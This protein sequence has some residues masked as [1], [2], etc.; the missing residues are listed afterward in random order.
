MGS[1]NDTATDSRPSE[2]HESAASA[3]EPDFVR[4]S[5]VRAQA[6]DEMAAAIARELNGPLTALLLYMG[7]IKHH[8][9]QL[10]PA[11]GDRA[12]LQRVVENALAQTERVCGLV[13]QLAG[14]HKGGLSAPSST[15]EAESRAARVLQPPRAPSADLLGPSGQ[16]RLT[17]REREVLRLI[18]EGYS[19]KQGAL[20]M[21]ISPRTFE[22][23]RAEAMRKLGARNTADLVRAALLHAID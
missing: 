16:K 23:H 17:K 19:N 2:W 7:E 9:D 4:L 8:S 14:A 13:K 20:R 3:E 18:S 22:S 15:E 21:Q 5:A 1:Q 10:V 6:A 12:Y 11:M